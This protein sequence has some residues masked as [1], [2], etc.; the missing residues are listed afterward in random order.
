MRIN[1]GFTVLEAMVTMAIVAILLGVALPGF[2][3]ISEE[4]KAVACANKV[5]TSIH[6]ARAE[7]VSLRQQ[8]NLV[9][10]GN[11]EWMMVNVGT[12]A[13]IQNFECDDQGMTITSAQNIFSFSPNGF[14]TIPSATDTVTFCSDSLGSGRRLTI[15]TSGSTS[16]EKVLAGSGVCP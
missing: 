2:R 7:A 1:K 3:T 15:N 5:V 14:R 9:V 8:V 10:T 11:G 4:N 12:G 6:M 13:T 16:M